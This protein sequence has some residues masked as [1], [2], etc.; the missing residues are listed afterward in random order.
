[1]GLSTLAS[2]A[3]ALHR[4]DMSIN[5]LFNSFTSFRTLRG[6]VSVGVWCRRADWRCAWLK[7]GSYGSQTRV[8]VRYR[9]IMTID[10]RVHVSVIERE[11]EGFL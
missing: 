1:M 10:N 7:E 6:G 4:S 11:I 8:S 2:C 9:A 5:S 3:Y